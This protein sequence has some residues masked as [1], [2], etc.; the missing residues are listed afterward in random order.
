MRKFAISRCVF[1][2][3]TPRKKNYLLAMEVSEKE[4]VFF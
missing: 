2:K 1:F 3:E 4:M